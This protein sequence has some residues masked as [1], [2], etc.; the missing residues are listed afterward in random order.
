MIDHPID[1]NKYLVHACLEGPEAGV[2]YRGKGEIINN[3]FTTIVLPDYAEKLATDFT[4][5]ISPIYCGKKIDQLYFS[6][7][8]NNSFTV[9]GGNCRFHWLVNGKRLPINVEP[10]KSEVNL[11]GNGPYRWIE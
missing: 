6:E 4:V 3:E 9:Y 10:A 8:E 1:E 2:Y 11:Q 7:I 5:Q